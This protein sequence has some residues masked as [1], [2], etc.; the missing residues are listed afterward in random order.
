M[1]EGVRV[2]VGAGTE[3]GVRYECPHAG[4]GHAWVPWGYGEGIL[5]R[6]MGWAEGRRRPAWVSPIGT[7]MGMRA[8]VHDTDTDTRG[9][10]PLPTWDRAWGA[11]P[12]HVTPQP[13]DA[14]PPPLCHPPHTRCPHA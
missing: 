9:C 8:A 12:R 4:M 6:G 5:G 3:G 7:L 2:R 13:R 14:L 11:P 10:L 1:G